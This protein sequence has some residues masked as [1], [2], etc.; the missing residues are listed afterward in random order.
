MN[1]F[2]FDFDFGFDFNL[3][4]AV[5]FNRVDIADMDLKE[6][7]SGIFELNNDKKLQLH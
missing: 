5:D 6:L 7:P 1:V 3:D 2:G 4:I